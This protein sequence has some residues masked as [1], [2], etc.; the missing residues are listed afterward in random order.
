MTPVFLDTSGLIALINAD[1]QWHSRG[2][3]VAAIDGSAHAA[4]HNIA[5]VD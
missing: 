3:R 1:D 2:S 4:H 5:G